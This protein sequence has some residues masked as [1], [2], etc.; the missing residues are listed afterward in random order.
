MDNVVIE[1]DYEDYHGRTS[2]PSIGG[3]YYASMLATLEYLKRIKRQATAILLREIYP[4]FKIPVG[5]WF[6]RESVRAMF[7]SPPV[8]RTDSLDEVL[9]FLEKETKLGS[10]RWFSS[11]VLLR[12]IRFT[13]PIDEFLKKD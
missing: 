12:R 2:Y 7:N 5:V 1:G 11:S 8:L 3:C 4:G 6:V 10:N 13:R 9:E